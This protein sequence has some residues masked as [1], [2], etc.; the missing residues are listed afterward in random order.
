L[1]LGKAD[2]FD[3]IALLD[4]NIAENLHSKR[5]LVMDN[6]MSLNSNPK[7]LGGGIENNLA[8][9]YL[10]DNHMF[11]ILRPK[12]WLEQDMSKHH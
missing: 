3:H 12:H 8:H 10:Q 1:E 11:L 6:Y 2:S 7:S 9:K 5:F 4:I